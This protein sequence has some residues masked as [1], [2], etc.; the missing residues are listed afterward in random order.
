MSRSRFASSASRA[1]RPTRS[2]RR[3]S[4]CCSEPRPSRVA[5]QHR[6]V[7][8][9]RG[10]VEGRTAEHARATSVSSRSSRARFGSNVPFDGVVPRRRRVGRPLGPGASWSAS[11]SSRWSAVWPGS[12]RSRRRCGAT[13][14]ARRRRRTVLAALGARR[15]DRAA[16]QLVAALPFLLLRPSSRLHSPTRSRRC[17]PSARRARWSP[18]P[19]CTRG[20]VHVRGRRTRLAPRRYRR[21]PPRSPGSASARSPHPRAR[22]RSPASATAAGPDRAA[23]RHRRPL[24]LCARWPPARIA[25]DGP[26]GLVIA[27]AGVVGSLMFVASLNDFTSTSARVR[28][29]LRSLA[30]SCR[31]STPNAVLD[32]LAADPELAAVRRGAQ[33]SRRRRRP[34]SRRVQHRAGQGRAEPGRADRRLPT[35]A[36]EIAIGPKLLAALGKHIGDATYRSRRSDG[37][38]AL[39]DRRHRVLTDRPRARRSTARSC[40]RP[41]AST[42]YSTQP[43]RRRRSSGSAPAPTAMRCS[44][45]LDQRFPTG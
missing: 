28:R 11:R 20:L 34:H 19:G 9:D 35:G 3:R 12:S 22:I 33:W 5:P 30:S 7:D 27:V 32:R 31:T 29:D 45:H 42:K 4:S 14:R 23:G 41:R 6:R 16:V 2:S 36:T 17:S 39:D 40:S 38:A 18:I 10:L 43:V 13:S 26:P 1:T 8:G 25:T 21:S 37:S 24:R 44:R 15:I